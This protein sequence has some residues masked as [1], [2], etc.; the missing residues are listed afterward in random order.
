MFLGLLVNTQA[1]LIFTRDIGGVEN[2]FSIFANGLNQFL[3][4]SG[5]TDVVRPIL[6]LTQQTDGTPAVGHGLGMRFETQTSGVPGSPV[7]EVGD[8]IES[9]STNAT[10]GAEA[11]DLVFKNMSGG[12][13]ASETFRILSGGGIKI[14][15]GIIATSSSTMTL[16]AN[17][18]TN[19]QVLS[20]DATVITS[21]TQ[22]APTTC[23]T[24]YC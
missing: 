19:G 11:F 5:G 10:A 13:A 3:Y 18:G 8:T 7:N 16:P 22:P 20:T 15:N 17:A 6:K 2:R 1:C 4:Q 24:C 21:W 23:S 9:T 14:P 12:A